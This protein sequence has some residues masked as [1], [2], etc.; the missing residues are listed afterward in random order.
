MDGFRSERAL[1]LG[2]FRQAAIDLRKFRKGESRLARELFRDALDWV[3]SDDS[4]W[5]YSFINVCRIL[6]VPPESTRDDMLA[7]AQSGWYSH[8][9]NLTRAIAK[10]MSASLSSYFRPQETFQMAGS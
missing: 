4:D 10:R 6:D 2:I 1:A 8:S 3:G 5:P 7:D 9:R